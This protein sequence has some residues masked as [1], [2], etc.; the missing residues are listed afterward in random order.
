MKD[1]V[2]KLI[3]ANYVL[4][5]KEMEV[6]EDTTTLYSDDFDKRITL[7]KWQKDGKWLA[8]AAPAIK[9]TTNDLQGNSS[10]TMSQIPGPAALASPFDTEEQ[11]H[12]WCDIHG[13]TIVPAGDKRVDRIYEL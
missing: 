9:H 12:E 13:L 6:I 7:H 11:A 8:M 3:P 10:Y 2:Y 5:G 1:K 4:C